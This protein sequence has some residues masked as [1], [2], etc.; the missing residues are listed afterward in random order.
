MLRTLLASRKDR[1][2]LHRIRQRLFDSGAAVKTRDVAVSYVNSAK[3]E[4]GVLSYSPYK[5]SLLNL[6]DFVVERMET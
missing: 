5:E 3:A 6:A 4:I 2:A 1:K